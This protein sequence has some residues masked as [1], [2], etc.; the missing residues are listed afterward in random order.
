MKYMNLFKTSPFLSPLL[1][2]HIWRNTESLP[3]N[4]GGVEFIEKQD[5]TVDTW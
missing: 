4:F 5:E 2:Q 3:I 1:L